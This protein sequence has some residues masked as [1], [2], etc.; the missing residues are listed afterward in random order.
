M[1][2]RRSTSFDRTRKKWSRTGCQY[3]YGKSTNLQDVYS[4]SFIFVDQVSGAQYVSTFP[5]TL[6]ILPASDIYGQGKTGTN[7]LDGGAPFYNVYECEGGG[8][9]TVGCLEPQFFKVFINR[10]ST[11]LPETFVFDNGWQPTSAMQSDRDQWPKMKAYFKQGFLTNTREYWG[12][13]FHGTQRADPFLPVSHVLVTSRNRRMCSS[14][15]NTKRGN[16]EFTF[17][18]FSSSCHFTKYQPIFSENYKYRGSCA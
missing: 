3:R 1:R 18:R 7:A 10:F 17:S 5:L 6:A 9:M 13:V 14:R 8:Y 2:G 4:V 11:A 16:A 12:N 15:I